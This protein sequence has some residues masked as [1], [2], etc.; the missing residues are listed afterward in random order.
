MRACV[1]LEIVEKPIV[2]F[3]LL[4]SFFPMQLKFSL[5]STT[6]LILLKI[7]ICNCNLFIYLRNRLIV[8]VI[9]VTDYSYKQNMFGSIIGFTIENVSSR[10]CLEATTWLSGNVVTCWLRGSGFYSRLYPETFV[11]GELFYGRYVQGVSVW[12]L[13]WKL[14]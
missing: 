9:R 3:F 8:L 1:L 5:I 4:F 6:P 14:L 7:W 10:L 2:Y 12:F 13:K 11:S